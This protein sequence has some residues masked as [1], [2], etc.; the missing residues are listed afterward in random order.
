MKVWQGLDAG[1]S[2]EVKPDRRARGSE[3]SLG[4]LMLCLVPSQYL[5]DSKA[6][7]LQRAWRSRSWMQDSLGQVPWPG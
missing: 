4:G 3:F 1:D 6:G 7:F 5:F 2:Q